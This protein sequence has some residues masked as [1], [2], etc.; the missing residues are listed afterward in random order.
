[1]AVQDGRSANRLSRRTVL[2]GA[3]A[4]AGGL[5]A[6][7]AF[8]LEPRWLDVTRHDVP[9]AGLPGALEGLTIVQ[10]TD[11][12]LS[13]LGSLHESIFETVR[14]IDPQIVVLT[15]DMVDHGSSAPVLEAFC[16]GIAAPG[17]VLL[18]TL[19]NWEHWGGVPLEV[20]QEAY[21]K[22]G[23]RLLVNEHCVAA[24][25]VVAGT[26]DYCSNNHDVHRTLD[27][28]PAGEARLLLSHAPGLLDVMPPGAPRFDLA[29][30]GHTHGGQVSFFGHAIVLPPG[31]GRFVAGAYETPAGPAYVSRGIGTSDLNV[32]VMCRPEL[33]I[34]RLVRG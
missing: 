10:L 1:M 3:A 17:R 29:L 18:A 2:R 22:S 8:G 31:C 5:I 12:H 34:F 21:V 7:D 23:T 14:R 19:G 9:V 32:R 16:R 33:P 26:D 20:I 25:V 4:T 30:S 15:G 27:G 28:L 13:S 11:V 24:G 6:L